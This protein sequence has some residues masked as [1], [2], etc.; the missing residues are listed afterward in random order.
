MYPG[1]HVTADEVEGWGVVVEAAAEG[2]VNIAVEE[3]AGPVVAPSLVVDDEV[4]IVVGDGVVGG[5]C[6]VVNVGDEVVEALEVLE[7]VVDDEV[8][9]VVGYEVVGGPCVVVNVGD[10]VVEALEVLEELAQTRVDTH[11]FCVS[12]LRQ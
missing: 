9:T 3:V 6:V 2:D 4:A 11:M 10:D 7:L 5:P 8:A 12:F 1:A